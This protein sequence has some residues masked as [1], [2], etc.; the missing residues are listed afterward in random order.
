MRQIDKTW[1]VREL[2]AMAEPVEGF[3]VFI[4]AAA[5]AILLV[6][7]SIP[8]AIFRAGQRIV[9]NARAPSPR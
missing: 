4:M 8:W 1:I 3:F 7:I 2:D 9:R 6:P 5:L